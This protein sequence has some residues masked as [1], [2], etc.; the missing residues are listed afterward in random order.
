[1]MS[2]PAL[3]QIEIPGVEPSHQGKVRDIFDLGEHLLLVATDRISAYDCILPQGIPDKGAIL[4]QMTRFWLGQLEEAEPNHL[5]TTEVSEFPAPFCDHPSQ[6]EGRSMLVHK[7]EP[8]PVECVVR[9]YLTGSG[10]KEYQESQTVGK[11]YIHE[12][13]QEFDALP[14]P[15]FSPARKNQEGHDENISFD[16]MIVIV[17]GWE[18]EELRERSQE[19]YRE[20]AEIA[21]DRGIILAD[22]K[23][24]FGILEGEILLIDEVLTP[25]SSRFW[26]AEDYQPGTPQAPYDKQLVRNYLRDLPW[27]GNPPAPDL[28]PEIIEQTRQRYIEAYQMLTGETW[29][30]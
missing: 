29:P 8:M 12:Q 27:D 25:D 24:E 17:G 21:K 16:E 2:R 26:R 23:F 4:T 7:T 6:L 10:W 9:G 11:I 18:G 20:A 1:M 3:T 15:I 13:L 28:P 19:L 14:R 22:T 5:V 30:S